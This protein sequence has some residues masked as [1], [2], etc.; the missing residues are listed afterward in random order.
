MKNK[1]VL[2]DD[3][4]T[5]T[6]FAVRIDQ[7]EAGIAFERKLNAEKDRQ[8]RDMAEQF[9]HLSQKMSVST[10]VSQGEINWFANHL[11]AM[12]DEESG[13]KLQTISQINSAL[14]MSLRA[15]LGMRWKR[16]N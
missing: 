3:P 16:E 8:L 11:I 14:G 2:K 12:L 6:Q 5:K 9:K 4:F 13:A 10:Q 7:L 15:F 1:D